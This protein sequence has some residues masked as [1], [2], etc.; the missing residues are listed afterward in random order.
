MEE[1]VTSLPE[2]QGELLVVGGHH[3]GLR[4]LLGLVHEVRNVLNGLV[5]LL[6]QLH[7][8]SIV[9]LLKTSLQIHLGRKAQG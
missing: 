9:Q 8:D 2:H 1:H 4:H 7:L 3:M 5:S 6:P